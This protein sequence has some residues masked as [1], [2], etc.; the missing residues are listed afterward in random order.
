MTIL[1]E[2]LIEKLEIWAIQ[3]SRFLQ[4]L[5]I[6]NFNPAFE[7]VEVLAVTIN[8]SIL[9]SNNHSTITFQAT[10]SSTLTG[11]KGVNKAAKSRN[12]FNP[13]YSH[14]NGRKARDP[15]GGW[16]IN[17]TLKGPSNHFKAMESSQ[18]SLVG[19]ML[20]ATDLISLDLDDQVAKEKVTG[21]TEGSD[22]TVHARVSGLKAD[23]I[24]TKWRFERTRWVESVGLSGG[25]WLGRKDSINVEIKKRRLFWKDLRLSIP[26]CHSPWLAIEDFNAIPL[27]GEKKGG[28]VTDDLVIFSKADLKH[29]ELLKDLIGSFCGSSRYKKKVSSSEDKKLSFTGR[30]TLAQSVILS[31]SSCLVESLMVS[32]GVCDEIE[33]LVRH[34]IWGSSGG[35]RNMT[36]VS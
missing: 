26:S 22:S 24:I 31:I 3:C 9:N 2:F 1:L 13:V 6:K 14:D 16:K 12:T 32:K 8:E 4:V 36:L 11:T 35:S 28:Q 30:V 5:M 20:M 29:S 25:I 34:F 27:A 15:K 33:N 19:S 10:S 21:E 7:E 17:K 18:V 23:T